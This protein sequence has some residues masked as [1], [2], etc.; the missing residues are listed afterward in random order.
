MFPSPKAV[1]YRGVG[2]FNPPPPNSEVFTKS[3]RIANWAENVYCSYS[4]IL[5][6]LKF[7]EYRTPTTQDVRK[8]KQ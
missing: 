3:N 6:S 1:A 7:A 8:K 5:I 4:N 2:G